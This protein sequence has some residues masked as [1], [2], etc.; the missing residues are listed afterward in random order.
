MFQSTN[1]DSVQS[2]RK[3]NGRDYDSSKNFG[4][5]GSGIREPTDASSRP[6][7]EVS[8]QPESYDGAQSIHQSFEQK[9]APSI[10]IKNIL[11]QRS[12]DARVKRYKD[13]K[14]QEEDNQLKCVGRDGAL[15]KNEKNRM[16]T[17]PDFFKRYD[18]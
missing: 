13:N 9:S 4:N 12:Q 18:V 1:Y 17:G 15:K 8:H 10:D 11:K 16:Q 14:R 3:A 7:L 2:L 6:R 5:S